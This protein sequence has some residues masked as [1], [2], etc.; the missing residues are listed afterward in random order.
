M[1][2]KQDMLK[3]Q[4][5]AAI[6]ASV[7]PQQTVCSVGEFTWTALDLACQIFEKKGHSFKTL[8]VSSY[9]TLGEFAK[10]LLTTEQLNDPNPEILHFV[11]Q[12]RQVGP[13]L[14]DA[15]NKKWKPIKAYVTPKRNFT[16]R[17][18]PQ[19][20][21]NVALLLSYRGMAVKIIVSKDE[22]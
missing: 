9:E 13:G 7:P 2:K 8:I 12:P 1:A 19:I 10:Q 15:P 18:S 5:Y 21:P 11:M 4:D 20:P 22:T 17:V 14:Q 3:K 6:C 16:L